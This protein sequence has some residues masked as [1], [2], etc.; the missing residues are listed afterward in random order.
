V[1]WYVAVVTACAPRALEPVGVSPPRAHA[2]EVRSPD[3]GPLEP[4]PVP[5]NFRSQL[6]RVSERFLSRGH[7]QRFDAI[8][9]ATADASSHLDDPGQIPDGAMLV[10]EAIERQ[11]E[12]DRAAGLLVMIRRSGAWR[13]IAVAPD[14]RVVDANAATCKSCHDEAPESVFP[15]GHQ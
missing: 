4:S 6:T 10:E 3:G 8:A 12:G 9:W 15:L 11:R 2:S 7:G 1:P 14:G 5:P 13:F